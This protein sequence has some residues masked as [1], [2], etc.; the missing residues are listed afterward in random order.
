ME[1]QEAG[2]LFFCGKYGLKTDGCQYWSIHSVAHECIY[3]VI[4]RRC[5]TP[6]VINTYV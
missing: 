6:L 2:H 5:M 4:I 3:F 1:L